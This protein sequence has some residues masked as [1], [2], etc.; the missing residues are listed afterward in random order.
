MAIIGIHGKIQME[1]IL[2]IL[3][4]SGILGI[5]KRNYFTLECPLSKEEK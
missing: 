4:S 3:D 1:W 5:L 2:K